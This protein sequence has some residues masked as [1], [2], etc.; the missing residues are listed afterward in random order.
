MATVLNE[1]RSR[2][3]DLEESVIN[4]TL[5][6]AESGAERSISRVIIDMENYLRTLVADPSIQRSSLTISMNQNLVR[7]WTRN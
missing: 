3:Q 7:S 4:T 2:L 1:I 6:V 5:P